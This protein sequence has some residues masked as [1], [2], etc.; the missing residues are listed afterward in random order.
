MGRGWICRLV[1]VNSYALAEYRTRSG[2][3]MYSYFS[4]GV[5]EPGE[6][7]SGIKM[8]RYYQGEGRGIKAGAGESLCVRLEVL[9]GTQ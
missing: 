4:A 2:P 8:Q 9:T 5:C 3:N 6:C 1:N 7:N